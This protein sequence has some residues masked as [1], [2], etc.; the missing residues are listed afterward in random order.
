VPQANLPEVGSPR[1]SS[2]SVAYASAVNPARLQASHPMVAG[3]A[4]DFQLR[5]R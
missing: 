4:Y 5:G 3:P 2:W 1:A